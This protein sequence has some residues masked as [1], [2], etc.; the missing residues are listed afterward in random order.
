MCQLALVAGAVPDRAEERVP[1]RNVGLVED[2][3]GT[4]TTVVVLQEVAAVPGG[5]EHVLLRV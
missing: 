1:G 3:R 4:W 5:I 2:L